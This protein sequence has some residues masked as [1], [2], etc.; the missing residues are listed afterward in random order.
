MYL[1]Y[2]KYS[3]FCVLAELQPPTGVIVEANGCN[4]ANV[5]WTPTQLRVCD[6]TIEGYS[7]RYQQSGTGGYSTV[8]T[9]STSVTLQDLVPNAEYTVSVATITSVGSMSAFSAVSRL[10]MTT[11]NYM[12]VQYSCTVSSCIVL[13]SLH[14][15]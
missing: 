1:N 14:P 4:S 2:S 5:A 15:Q 12:D 11:G 9:S 7:V 10:I 6:A 8:N 3:Y 13:W